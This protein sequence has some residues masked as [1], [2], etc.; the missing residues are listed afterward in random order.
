MLLMSCQFDSFGS[1]ALTH[2]RAADFETATSITVP[3]NSHN[4]LGLADCALT[5]RNEW[6]NAPTDAVSQTCDQRPQLH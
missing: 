4:V 2:A 6:T 5:I 3:G 1:P